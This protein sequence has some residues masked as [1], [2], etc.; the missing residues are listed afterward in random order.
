[1]KIE[2]ELYRDIM[3]AYHPLRLKIIN[4]LKE[5]RGLHIN[6]IAKRI[7]EDRRL[8]SYHL[9]ILEEHEFVRSDF[10]ILRKATSKGKIG[11]VFELTDKFEKI[12]QKLA[13]FFSE[14]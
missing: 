13:A 4:L 2:S 3:V 9:S 11:R 5:K 8:T 14:V 10:Q 12:R 1:L 6:E 7:G